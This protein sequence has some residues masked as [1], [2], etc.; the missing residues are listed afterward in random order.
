MQLRKFSVIA[1]LSVVVS[2][3]VCYLSKPMSYHERLI[4]IQTDQQLARIDERIPNE[5]T[6]IQA[7]L[8][9]YSGDK[10]LQ[11]KAWIALSTYPEQSREV[12]RL[13]GGEQEF[14]DILRQ[15][16]ETV[17]PVVK[18]F[19]D[20]SVLS[21]QVVDAVKKKVQAVSRAFDDAWNWM[22]GNAA[23]P[24]NSDTA[25][26]QD[27]IGS[28]ERGWYAIGFV[29]NEGHQFLAQ[30]D[31]DA[32]GEPKWNQ[33]NRVVTDV[34][35]FFS[36]GIANL[37]MKYD[38]HD[39]VKIDDVFFAAID[40]V[41][42]VASLKLLKAGKVATAS[43]NELSLVSRTRI[44]APKLIPKGGIFLRFGKYAAIAATAY[45]VVTHPSLLNSLFLEV[46]NLAGL[47]PLVVQ[48]LG[49]AVIIAIAL[50][51]FTW[52]LTGFARLVLWC[53]S[54]FG[55]TPLPRRN[56]NLVRP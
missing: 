53:A 47:N 1:V 33:T 22:R 23:N 55:V 49:W 41:P 45:V 2:C 14:K 29:R 25:G 24:R 30:F 15:Y 31:V 39:E 17:I 32:A 34:S 37:E 8:L 50:Y 54:A 46:A 40:V 48:F 3:A 19:V 16:G 26:Q 11:L 20:H 6:D 21:I 13:Y 27:G 10:V 42:L 5:P 9:D 38:L 36:S 12:L 18:Y 35:S 44:F 28:V 4:Q 56:R 52:F 43:G 7:L 51:P